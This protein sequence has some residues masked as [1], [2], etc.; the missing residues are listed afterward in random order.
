MQESARGGVILVDEASQLG[1]RD[2]LAV[3]DVAGA[4]DARVILVGDRRQHRS[5]TA[6]EPL[7]LL[8]ETAGLQGGRSHRNPAPAGRLQE[9][10]QGSER[11]PR[12][13]EAFKELDKLGWIKQVDDGERYQRTGR[14]Y[15]A[16]VARKEAG[17]RAQDR[18]WSSRRRM[19]RRIASRLRSGTGSRRKAS[20]AKSASSI[21]G[22]RLT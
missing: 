17:R 16:A 12:A 19:P 4:V 11:R 5:V 14:A 10:G 3:F 9:G 13:E 21:P 20:S 2:M 15:L 18:R 6:G 1:T 8:E 22:C 7:K